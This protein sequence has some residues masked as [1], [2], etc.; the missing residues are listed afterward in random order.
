M[1]IPADIAVELGRP[2]LSS[3]EVDQWQSWID[4][5]RY[6]I[7]KRLGNVA[8]LD[9]ADVDYVVLQAVAAHVRNPEDATQVDVAVDDG[10]VSK[11]YATGTGRVTIID[12]WWDLLTPDGSGAVGA[13]TISPYGAPDT[14]S[15]R[16]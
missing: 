4:Q 2:S 16:A 14:C 3:A 15:W 8:A 10:R 6:L 5:A 9:Q 12:E 13:F 7:G 1:V 11:R